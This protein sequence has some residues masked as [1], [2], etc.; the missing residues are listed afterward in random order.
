MKRLAVLISGGGTNLQAIIDATA[1]GR[2]DAEIA[3]VVSNKSKAFGLERARR[4][5]IETLVF[6]A[7]GYRGREGWRA[8]FDADLAARVVEHR[9]DLIVLAGW[10]HVLSERFLERFPRRVINLHPA[11]PGQ[12]AG[13]RAIERA[14]E[15]HQRGE[16]ERSGVMVHWV[17]PEIDAGDPITTAEVPFVS[18]DT[19]EEFEARVHE[20]EHRLIVEAIETALNEMDR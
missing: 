3:V 16:L 12:F 17:I 4:A 1:A 19:M 2:L 11:L 20:T 6:T 18:G 5:R 7:K 8:D 13:T 10:M 14:F 15:A 9:P